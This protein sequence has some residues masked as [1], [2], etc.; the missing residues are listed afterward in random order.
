[1]LKRL[2]YTKGREVF[3]DYPVPRHFPTYDNP[4]WQDKPEKR[5][6]P[7][8]YR[9][10]KPLAVANVAWGVPAGID[11]TKPLSVKGDGDDGINIDKV[12]AKYDATAHEI[13]LTAATA[14]K[15]F[16]ANKTKYYSRFTITWWISD[17]DGGDWHEG[18][19][20]ENP[21]YVCLRDLQA[22]PTPYRTVCHLACSNDG[23]TDADTAA[24]KTWALFTS[25]NTGPANVKGWDEEAQ[26]WTRPLYYYKAGT[27]FSD[28]STKVPGFLKSGTG[29]CGAWKHLLHDAWILNGADSQ[30]YQATG[31]GTLDGGRNVVMFLVKDWIYGVS[32]TGIDGLW[33]LFLRPPNV[34]MVPLPA[35]GFGDLTSDDTKP[36]Q[37]SSPPSEKAFTEHEFLKY[38]GKYYD[39]SYGVKYDDEPNF[40]SKAVAGWGVLEPA[41]PPNPNNVYFVAKDAARFT[42]G[43]AFNKTTS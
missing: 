9:Q 8:L 32:S 25:D 26:S 23:A 34:E 30:Y 4:Q 40:I 33:K 18:G 6:Y 15:T 13:V 11:T 21:I 37:N 20:S 2:S 22:T 16:D 17:N 31:T 38:D 12:A 27:K 3:R 41:E 28:N 39:P 35:G 1:V 42:L 5:R 10:G 19:K 7:Y 24:A 14:S 43:I 29:Q 36:G